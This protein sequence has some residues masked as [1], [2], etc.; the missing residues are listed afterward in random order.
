MIPEL[1]GIIRSSG[2]IQ[3]KIVPGLIDGVE[4]D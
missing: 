2:L 3:V 1:G 4:I